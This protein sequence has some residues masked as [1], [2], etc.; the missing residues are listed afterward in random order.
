MLM[1]ELPAT[2]KTWENIVIYTLLGPTCSP[3]NIHQIRHMKITS[4]KAC[5]A[6]EGF[7]ENPCFCHVGEQETATQVDLF[8]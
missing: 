4:Q 1:S 2:G 5:P 7:R 8:F 6:L 3:P